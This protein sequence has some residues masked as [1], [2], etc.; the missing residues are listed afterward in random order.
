[1]DNNTLIEQLRQGDE[2]AFRL[3]YSQ[4]YA[5]LCRYAQKM[6]GNRDEA[7][8][9]VDDVIFYLWTHRAEVIITH[10]LRSYLLR[11]VH[12]KCLNELKSA[13]RQDQLLTF[14]FFSD[15]SIAFLDRLYD[16]E[17]H[18]LGYLLQQ[19]LEDELRRAIDSLPF[20]CRRVFKKSRFEGKKY[21]EIASELGISVNTCKYHIKNA[22]ARLQ[23]HMDSYLNL[24]ILIFFT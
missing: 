1:M 3:L 17:A 22:L 2:R 16:N 9:I 10:S 14:S 6:M 11:A 5:I 18:P 13:A 7:E 4:H 21:E 20:E 24:L 19:E 15:E 12:N 23:K 8:E